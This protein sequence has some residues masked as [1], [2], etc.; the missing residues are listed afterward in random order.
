M[1]EI[2]RTHD[3]CIFILD[4]RANPMSLGLDAN[5]FINMLK[6]EG[7][8]AGKIK[9][10][11]AQYDGEEFYLRSYDPQYAGFIFTFHEVHEPTDDD[12]F[13]EID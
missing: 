10:I 6:Y 5:E 1:R 2:K 7:L 9:R 13:E 12:F 3:G 11:I 4:K 8:T